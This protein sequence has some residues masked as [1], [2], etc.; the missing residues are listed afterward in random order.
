MFKPLDNILLCL[1]V[2]SFWTNNRSCAVLLKNSTHC[3]MYKGLARKR[4]RT[5]KVRNTPSFLK[6]KTRTTNMFAPVHVHM[7][8]VP[9]PGNRKIHRVVRVSV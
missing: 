8:D 7:V 6:E 2:F 9:V 4:I 1:Q 3:I 5:Q